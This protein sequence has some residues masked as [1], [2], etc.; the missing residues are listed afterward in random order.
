MPVNCATLR[1]RRKTA[2]PVRY[3][4]G[5]VGKLPLQIAVANC[6]PLSMAVWPR[7]PV[8]DGRFAG[9]L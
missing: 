1:F 4:D 8:K 6:R 2:L 5:F 9:T 7:A 3:M